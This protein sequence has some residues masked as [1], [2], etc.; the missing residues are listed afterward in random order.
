MREN[1]RN[2]ELDMA[3]IKNR[4]S[5]SGREYWAHVDSV[6][7]Q[8]HQ[9]RPSYRRD[10]SSWTL[11]RERSSNVAIPARESRCV[12]EPETCHRSE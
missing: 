2:E 12:P 10:V 1:L 5:D 4:T 8:V 9:E 3:L 11:A 7:S 6:V